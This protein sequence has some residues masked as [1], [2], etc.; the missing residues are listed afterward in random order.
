MKIGDV[1]EKDAVVTVWIYKAE[2]YTRLEKI[3]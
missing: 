3:S 1:L 2:N